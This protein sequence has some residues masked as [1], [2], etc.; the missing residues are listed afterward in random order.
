MAQ[1]ETGQETGVAFQRGAED[2]D[3]FLGKIE[4]VVRGSGGGREPTRGTAGRGTKDKGGGT[5][6][7][8]AGEFPAIDVVFGMGGE[9]MKS[10]FRHELAIPVA[11]FTNCEREYA[12][13]LR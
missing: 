2:M 13:I 12:N 6:A 11:Q 10:R 4:G 5:D 8:H 1:L 9:G 7:E 3:P